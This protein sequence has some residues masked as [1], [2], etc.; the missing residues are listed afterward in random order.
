VASSLEHFR[1]SYDVV[2]VGAR[3]AG[4]ATAMLLA[5]AGASV[6]LLERGVR[7][8]DTLSTLALMRGGVLQLSRWGLVGDLIAAGTPPIRTTSFYYGDERVEIPIKARDGVDALLAPRRTVLDTVLGDAAQAAGAD[9][10]FRVRVRDLLRD[11]TGRVMGVVCESAGRTRSISSSVVV[12][13]DGVDSTVAARVGAMPYRVARNASAVIYRLIPGQMFEGYQWHYRPGANVGVIPTNHGETVVFAAAPQWRFMAE[14][15]RDLRA[16]F[17]AVVREVAPALAD[18]IDS[19]ASGA[20][21]GFAGHR[22]FLRPAWGPGWAL[23]GD[24]G[25]FKDPITAHGLTD[26][27]RDAGEVARAIL[28]GTDAALAR[29]QTVRDG[30]SMPLFGLTDE[31]ASFS[32]DLTRL[33]ALHRSL[34]EE[35]GR[36]VAHL[37]HAEIDKGVRV[38]TVPD[39][40]RTLEYRE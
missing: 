14:L 21:H 4:A 19:S 11:R 26:A 30:L 35:M 40:V 33:R 32:W 31:I 28:A 37:L 20:V 29:W 9:V 2:V 10:A 5:R 1:S 6:I 13:A 3:A 12:G 17:D 27:L 8:A 7:G 38:A 23:V 25:Y 36:E 24:A 18:T 15:R 34:S 22:G 39:R 16:G